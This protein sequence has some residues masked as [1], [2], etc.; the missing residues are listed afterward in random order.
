MNN[1]VYENTMENLRERINFALFNNAKGFMK[2]TNKPSSV[3][4]KIFNKN[5]VA[6]HHFKPVLTI[7][8]INQSM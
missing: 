1:S 2:Y 4:Q 7:Q 5:F 8:L 3:S 6:I